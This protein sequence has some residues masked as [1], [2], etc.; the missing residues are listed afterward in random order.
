M[1]NKNF[2]QKQ[3]EE[4]LCRFQLLKLDSVVSQFFEKDK[5]SYSDK[6]GKNHLVSESV[7]IQD[8]LAKFKK[9]YPNYLPYFILETPFPSY[10]FTMFSIFYISSDDDEWEFEKS[11][12]QENWAYVNVYNDSLEEPY[13]F[14]IGSIDFEKSSHGGLVR[15]S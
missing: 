14:E 6:I 10:D 2:R 15:I 1:L 8:V 11:A 9:E 13:K 4:A 3:K 5:L 7:E 12:I